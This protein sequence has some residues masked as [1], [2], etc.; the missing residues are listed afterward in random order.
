MASASSRLQVK[1]PSGSFAYTTTES[2]VL[3]LIEKGLATPFY[4][5]SSRGHLLGCT[6][7]NLNS[8]ITVCQAN[9]TIINERVETKEGTSVVR[10]HSS[11]NE[12][13]VM[14]DK[15]Y[16]SGW[17]RPGQVAAFRSSSKTKEISR[18]HARA[19]I[20]VTRSYCIGVADGPYC[21]YAI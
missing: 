10:R 16:T 7:I 8:R 4:A 17:S 15:D 6:L 19:R 2:G 18:P 11:L 9:R 21:T 3:S 14:K 1:Y 13:E 12:H 20:R 5:R